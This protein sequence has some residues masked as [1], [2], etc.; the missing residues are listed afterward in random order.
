MDNT[1]EAKRKI[2]D[3][4]KHPKA[5]T[6][7]DTDDTAL[8]QHVAM[9][10]NRKFANSD[11]PDAPDGDTD[12]DKPAPVKPMHHAKRITIQP[13]SSPADTHND[14]ADTPAPADKPKSALDEQTQS[15]PAP[16]AARNAVQPAAPAGGSAPAPAPSP[17]PE[18]PATPATPDDVSVPAAESDNPSSDAAPAEPSPAAKKALEE[19]TKREGEIQGYIASHEFFV[20]INTEARKRSIKVSIG[21]T[22]II[23]I[24]AIVLIDL[25]LDTDIIL[26]LQKIPHTHFFTR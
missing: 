3:V 15:A 1:P 24:L 16:A 19:A 7:D 25:M 13:L 6:A 4:T 10:A 14:D 23:L 9:A 11:Q 2:M 8:P 20:P 18:V 12:A 21:L 17:S 26:L 22:I 5:H